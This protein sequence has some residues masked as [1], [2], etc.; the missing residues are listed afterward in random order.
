MF[1]FLR[2]KKKKT[3]NANHEHDYCINDLSRFGVLWTIPWAI[4]VHED[5]YYL[6]VSTL[7]TTH[8]GGTA[9][10]K[11]SRVDGQIVASGLIEPHPFEDKSISY[12]ALQF[13]PQKFVE[14]QIAKPLPFDD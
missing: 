2:G 5:K 9:Q 7:C 6:H 10:M 8:P 12:N 14:I 13:D 4:Y 3:P 11:L 1:D